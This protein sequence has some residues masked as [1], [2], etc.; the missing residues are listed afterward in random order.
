MPVEQVREALELSGPIPAGLVAGPGEPDELLLD[1]VVLVLEFIDQALRSLVVLERVVEAV[2]FGFHVT[3]ESAIELVESGNAEAARLVPLIFLVI[4]GTV[5]VYGLFAP[6]VAR[7]L[8][9]AT[10]NPQGML[11]IGA[12]RWVRDCAALLQEQG[13]K[14]VLADSNWANV[15]AARRQGLRTCY[16]NVLT[17]GALEEIEIELDGVGRL[18]ALT[19]NDEVNALATLHFADLFDRAQM[20]QLTRPSLL[21]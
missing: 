7:G 6:L 2:L 5:T 12:A 17:E 3:P 18:L 4:V 19:P 16:T 20:Y 21:G 13:I 15:T 9:V 8:R 10:P 11:L 14:V 1:V